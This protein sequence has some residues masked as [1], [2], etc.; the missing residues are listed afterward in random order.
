[1]MS[2][3]ELKIKFPRLR[4]TLMPF[5]LAETFFEF[6][7]V[8]QKSFKH[9]LIEHESNS[10]LQPAIAL[11]GHILCSSTFPTFPNSSHPR[12]HILSSSQASRGGTERNGTEPDTR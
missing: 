4:L 12:A 8:V 5:T 6:L 3:L 11:V 7:I 1:M 9:P 10:S 2:L